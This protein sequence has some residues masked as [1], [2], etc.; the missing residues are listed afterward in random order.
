[1]TQRNTINWIEG[2]TKITKGSARCSSCGFISAPNRKDIIIEQTVFRFVRDKNGDLI[3]KLD[4]DGSQ[5]MDARGMP[6]FKKRPEKFHSLVSIQ[7]DEFGQPK[8]ATARKVSAATPDPG[9]KT[10]KELQS[11]YEKMSKEKPKIRDIKPLTQ[12]FEDFRSVFEFVVDEETGQETKVNTG[13]K[14]HKQRCRGCPDPWIKV[15]PEQFGDFL[16]IEAA[17]KF[18]KDEDPG[19]NIKAWMFKEVYQPKKEESERP[20]TFEP[21]ILPMGASRFEQILRLSM[22]P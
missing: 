3:P 12:T 20:K 16:T 4:S 9:A 8:W 5:M 7:F 10:G 19:N 15:K 1:M 13:K 18:T 6:M 22:M 11:F 21:T 17:Y 14:E 2:K